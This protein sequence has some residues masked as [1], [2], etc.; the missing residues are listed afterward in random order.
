MTSLAARTWDGA[1]HTPLNGAVS[2]KCGINESI[3][4]PP[5]P[6]PPPNNKNLLPPNPLKEQTLPRELE[7]FLQPCCSLLRQL[8]GGHGEHT[9]AI[10]DEKATEEAEVTD[11]EEEEEEGVELLWKVV[12]REAVGGILV[13][14]ATVEGGGRGA[15]LIATVQVPPTTIAPPLFLLPLQNNST[16]TTPAQIPPPSPHPGS[17][18]TSPFNY[19]SFFALFLSFWLCL[20]LSLL[21]ISPVAE[22]HSQLNLRERLS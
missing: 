5:P 17:P 7:L 8:E 22:Q 2:I 11:D 16:N 10:L 20:F 6:P 3:R 1:W 9:D 4:P 19:L 15:G 14:A 12:S 21:T 13:V 18:V